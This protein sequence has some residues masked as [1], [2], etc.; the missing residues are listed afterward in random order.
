[1]SCNRRAGY[2]VQEATPPLAP[3]LRLLN[4]GTSTASQGSPA[5]DPT[6]PT[7]GD[8]HGLVDC[9][10]RRARSAWPKS[11]PAVTVAEA[12]VKSPAGSR[13]LLKRQESP[14]PRR[15]D[16]APVFCSSNG[17]RGTG[18]TR[19][20]H[21][22]AL[23]PRRSRRHLWQARQVSLRLR[24]NDRVKKGTPPYLNSYPS[25]PPLS[26]SLL[27]QGP[28]KGMLWK[29]SFSAKEAGPEPSY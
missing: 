17:S 1:M 18:A 22:A 28:G 8:G 4:C 5:C 11:G 13:P 19:I 24:H 25:P 3:M 2:D 14:L 27:L 23:T 12:A 26:L 7:K 20:S 15:E 29:G 9:R 16:D 6:V 21:P 10:D